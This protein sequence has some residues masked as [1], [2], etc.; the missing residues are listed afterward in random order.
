M[1]GNWNAK[2]GSQVTWTN[3]QIWPWSTKRSRSKADRVLPRERT[4]HNN[5][6]VRIFK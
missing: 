3:K 4:G 5:F 2:V 6:S 1:I